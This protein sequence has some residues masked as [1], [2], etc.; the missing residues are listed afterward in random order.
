VNIEGMSAAQAC[1]PLGRRIPRGVE[2][3]Y[4]VYLV[5]STYFNWYK[6]G[7]SSNTQERMEGMHL[8]F[9]LE[10][11]YESK[12]TMPMKTAWKAERTLHKLYAAQR[13][14]HEWFHSIDIKDFE[15]SA[16]K[17]IVSA[18]EL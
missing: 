7:I 17:E 15:I 12:I 1:K 2:L 11:F 4:H 14:Q 13:L 9:V 18:R 5:G 6:I 8:P 10:L 16:E 3:E